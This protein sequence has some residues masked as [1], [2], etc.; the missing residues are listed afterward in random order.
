MA[1]SNN[2]AAFPISRRFISILLLLAATAAYVVAQDLPSKIR[3][4]KLHK[5]SISVTKA[6]GS[7]GNL[8]IGAP[9][10]SDVSF[11]GVKFAVA[12]TIDEVPA[13]GRVDFLTFDDF[14]INGVPVTIDEYAESFQFKKGQGITLPKP[15]SVNV[16]TV[17]L[18]E[19]AQKGVDEFRDQWSVTGRVFVFGR[20]RKYGM[21]FRRVVPVDIDL[22]I[23]N[24]LASG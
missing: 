16:G 15:L 11:T 14:K 24:P 1:R 2:M 22:K 12:I 21:E 6:N 13:T 23:K 19:A 4:Y 17:G 7:A 20:F 8:K 10:L 18:L 3:G 9:S 5:K